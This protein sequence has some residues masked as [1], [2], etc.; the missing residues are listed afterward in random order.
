MFTRGHAKHPCVQSTR[1]QGL[2]VG[3]SQRYPTIHQTVRWNF[4]IVDHGQQSNG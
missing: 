2:A 4:V 3:P 1:L